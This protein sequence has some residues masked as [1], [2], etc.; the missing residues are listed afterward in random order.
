MASELLQI[1]IDVLRYLLPIGAVLI[2]LQWARPEKLGQKVLR[3]QWRLDLVHV[4]VNPLIVAPLALATYGS[5]KLLVLLLGDP[6]AWLAPQVALLPFWLQLLLATLV[7]DFFGYW[8]H[9][10]MHSTALWPIHAVHHSTE[11]M[12]WLS[13]NRF[14]PLNQVLTHLVHLGSLW[15][16]GFSPAAVAGSVVIRTIYGNYVH[17][18][19]DIH[20]GALGWLLV[21]PRCHRWHHSRRESPQGSNFGTVFSLWDTIFGTLYLPAGEQPCDFGLEGEGIEANYLKH[22]GYPALAWSNRPAP[23][24]KSN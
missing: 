12:D 18:N 21:S 11:V 22:L 5:M 13:T 6:N 19:V 23:E 7:S 2:C 10:A 17:A 20:Y 4:L 14:H 9:R 1:E 24:T 15:L 16:L 8:R 3:T